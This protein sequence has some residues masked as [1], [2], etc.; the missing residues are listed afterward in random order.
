METSPGSRAVSPTGRSSLTGTYAYRAPELL[1][2]EPPTAKADI[3][4]FGVTQWQMMSRQRPY[5]NQHQHC[6]IFGV[7]AYNVRP[8]Q[9]ADLAQGDIVSTWFRELYRQCWQADPGERPTAADTVDVF[10]TWSG[11]I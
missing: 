3:Y 7:V 8:E 6:V 1:R 2:G 5:E 10:A 9:P 4:S 11:V